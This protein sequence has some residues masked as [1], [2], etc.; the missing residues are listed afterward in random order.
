MG[1]AAKQD[2]VAKAVRE[3][4]SLPAFLR[5]FRF[6]NAGR[7][8]AAFL[9]VVAYAGVTSLAS[10]TTPAAA[11][12]DDLIVPRGLNAEQ[13]GGTNLR[14]SW[15]SFEGTSRAGAQYGEIRWKKSTAG[16]WIC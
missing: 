5:W 12:S 4:P 16:S 8:L 2:D 9:V 10:D 14:V 7:V 15:K 3:L 6:R 11:Q 1:G 13:W